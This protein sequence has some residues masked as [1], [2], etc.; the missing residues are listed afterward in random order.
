ME[1]RFLDFEE[2]GNDT[3]NQKIASTLKRSL[4]E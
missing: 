2:F 3:E 4:R 1:G